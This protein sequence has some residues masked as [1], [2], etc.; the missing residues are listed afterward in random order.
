M[1]KAIEQRETLMNGPVMNINYGH[2]R[3]SWSAITACPSNE[4]REVSFRDQMHANCTQ[5]ITNRTLVL[6]LRLLFTFAFAFAHSC[7]YQKWALEWNVLDAFVVS[8]LS[9]TLLHYITCS[10]LLLN[11]CQQMKC[12]MPNRTS[13][14]TSL[15]TS[16]Q[17][18]SSD[19]L[20]PLFNLS[21]VP[22]LQTSIS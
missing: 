14:Q 9:V 10:Q 5:I 18:L 11:C 1:S 21:S 4:S 22:F 2:T 7:N 19:S 3:I 17:N 15:Q 16:L 6:L 8:E 20:Q 13:M 12:S